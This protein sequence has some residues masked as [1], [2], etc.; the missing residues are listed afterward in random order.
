MLSKTKSC[1]VI[2]LDAQ[3]VEIEVDVSAGLGSTVVVGL[4]DAAVQEAKERVRSAI[5]NSGVHFP[6]S[7]LTINLAPADIKKEGPIYDLPIALGIILA[8]ERQKPIETIDDSLFVG[9]LALDGRLRPTR[10]ILPISIFARQKGFKKIFLPKSN[11][12]E[13]ALV[14][15]LE[16]FPVENLNQ[17]LSHLFGPALISPLKKTGD[18]FSKENILPEYDMAYIKGQENAKRALEIA[19]A[20][21]HNVLMSG[22]PGSGKTM[23]AKAI[24]GI[25]PQMTKEEILEVTKI[26]SVAGIL[27]IENPLIKQRPF[28]GPHHSASAIALIGGGQFP[29]PGEV[30]LS[31]RGILFLDELPEFPRHVLENL[32][33]PLE[34]GSVTISRAQG[35]LTFPANFS[36]I[37]SMNPCPCGFL[38]DPEKECRCSPSQIIN[39]Q[40]RISGPL[41]DRIDLCVEV[42]RVKFEKLSSEKVSE[43]SDDIQKRVQE[44]RKIQE[45]RFK[46]L[47]ISANAEM[48]PQMIK[49]FCQIDNKGQEILKNAVN[50]L[51]LSARA[52]HRILKLARTIADLS[53]EENIQVHHLAE[54]IQYRRKE[55][56]D[57]M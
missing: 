52:Y 29:R 25:L 1:A 47:K 31:H 43:S 39:Y 19:A 12:Q 23:L 56:R 7:R 5:K 3:L 18:F 30:S 49:D 48:K 36:L 26:Y 10:G 42:P 28:R 57:G 37:A 46:K 2:G 21:A 40:K 35:S 24:P 44:A 16:I 51:L 55:E 34:N 13:A 27:P 6:T 14:D 33:Q 45:K 22:P 54:A 53:K 20:G 41:L 11:A 9:E 17:L 38:T 15:N 32:R 50:Q 8:A 4:P